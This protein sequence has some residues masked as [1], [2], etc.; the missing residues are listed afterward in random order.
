LELI[1]FLQ[2]A[3][4]ISVHHGALAFLLGIT[5]LRASE[6]VAVHTEHW[7]DPLRGPLLLRPLSVGRST[8][9]TSTGW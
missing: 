7:A 1:W 4:T 5:A 3:E 6:A 9:A 2:V 8:A